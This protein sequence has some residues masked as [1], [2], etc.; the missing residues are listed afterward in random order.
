[1]QQHVSD[2]AV[3]NEPAM[4]AG[5]CDCTE[6]ND[7]SF[8]YQLRGLL[9]SHCRENMSGTPDYIL[10]DFLHSCLAAFDIAT[11]KRDKHLE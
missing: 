5:E 6:E 11:N 7:G 8:R 10:A 9:N 2:C 3:H 4:P 1:M